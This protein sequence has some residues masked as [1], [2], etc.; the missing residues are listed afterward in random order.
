VEGLLASGFRPR[1]TIYLAF[2]H[3]EE[4]GGR[5]GAAKIAAL[6]AARGVRAELSLDEGLAI[7]E[8]M[9]PGVPAPVA[10]V[11]IAEKGYLTV[12]LSVASEGGH[13]SMPPPH[14]AVGIL[15]AAVARLEANQL[16][17]SLDGPARR[18]F[19]W[20]GPEMPLGERVAFAN[21]WLFAP[22]VRA[23]LAA[24]PVTNALVRTTTAPTM[25]EGSIKE[26]VLPI[27]ARAVV[28][29]RIRPGESIASVVEHVRDA[30]ADDRVTVTP[31]V[32]GGSEP[33]A[34]SSVDSPGFALVHR[35]IREVFPTAL[36]A[37]SLVTAATD[38]KHYAGVVEDSYRFVPL[39]LRGED[40]ARFHGTDERIGVENFAQIVRFY[41]R[42][43]AS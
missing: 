38:S 30:V 25:L 10:L 37:P 27:R 42:L 24:L 26:N 20:L 1:R 5:E 14:T 3:D 11:G 8:E 18:L 31:D 22:L 2:G 36:V 39:W 40:R 33:S 32:A 28:N 16:P 29:F 17:T 7:I 35:T 9:L 43:I 23:R 19:E 15:S 6:L 13:S 4:V 21:L 34:V 12:E 41:A